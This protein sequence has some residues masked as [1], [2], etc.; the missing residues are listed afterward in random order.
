METIEELESLAILF[1]DRAQS[2]KGTSRKQF[3]AEYKLGEWK[4]ARV[5]PKSEWFELQ[6]K[7]VLVRVSRAL[8]EVYNS[9]IVRER[10]SIK[11]ILKLL[12]G[13]GIRKVKFM[14]LAGNE[15][16]KRRMQLPTARERVLM[17]IKDLVAKRISTRELTI[18]LIFKEAGVS[19]KHGPWFYDALLSAR[20]ELLEHQTS[21]DIPQPP[22]G[23]RA[24]TLPDG[25]I[26][27]DADIW[28]LR[29]GG[30]FCI[31]RHLLRSDI[32]DIA[33]PMMRD[34]LLGENLS[35]ATIS[36]YFRGYRC[37]GELL[38]SEVPDVRKATLERVQKAW[39]K[40]DSN[41]AN[42]EVARAALKRVFTHFCNPDPDAEESGVDVKEM[43][44]I[45]GWL[46]TSAMVHLSSPNQDFLSDA[47]MNA[48]IAGCLADI[49]IGLDFTES[50]RD[51]LGLFTRP[52]AGD[53]AALVVQWSSSLMILLMLFAGLRAQS[54]VNLNIGDWAEIRPGLFALIWSHGK[55]R[56]EKIAILATSLALLLNEYVKRTTKIRQ[57][58]GTEKVFLSSNLSSYWSAT[59]RASYHRD[60]LLPAF[61]KR[62]GLQ[63][64]GIPLKLNS[65]ILRRTYVTRELYMGRSIWALRLQLGHESIR[66][67]RRY[68]KFDLFEHPIEVGNAL[69]EYGRKSLIL[70][71]YPLL[72]ADLDSDERELLLG[73]KE[74][75][76]QDVGLCRY[77]CCRKILSGNPPPCSLCENLVTGPEFLGGWDMEKKGR[78]YEIERLQSTPN[79]NHLLEQ[80]KSQ[81]KMFR[82]NLAYVKGEKRP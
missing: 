31:K 47:E 28:D 3:Q 76:H 21:K 75:R 44:L 65:Q 7:W 36:S 32:A 8:D 69:D 70:W 43:L 80:K 42:F 72:L 1:F 18:K 45:S 48:T 57:S 77:D 10:F 2:I 41:P 51:L 19:P 16:R 15:W 50:E 38:G 64:G 52:R 66:M 53:N 13:T 34:A 68:G 79:A 9:A 29:A 26:D 30:G 12:Q 63:R 11:R 73:V 56:E 33:W 4:A 60:C 17:V 23:V 14:N 61:I 40:Y 58:L 71:K 25:W 82:E 81:Y 55:K 39:L 5:F 74:E 59:Q 62:H 27:L 49:K 54:V 67:T 78:V 35:C 46:Y 22:D 37:A 6:D 24:L 20:Q